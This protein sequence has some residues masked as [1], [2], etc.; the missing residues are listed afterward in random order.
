M[1]PE[2]SLERMMAI[3]ASVQ[4][5]ASLAAIEVLLSIAESSGHGDAVGSWRQHFA[6]RFEDWTE[7]A[8]KRMDRDE[9]EDG[10]PSCFEVEASCAALRRQVEE[11]KRD[12]LESRNYSEAL[13]TER[14]RLLEGKR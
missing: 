12:L 6:S 3:D 2:Q 8:K 14:D 4:P 5:S 11:I 1:T 9:D 10:C 13:A 7:E